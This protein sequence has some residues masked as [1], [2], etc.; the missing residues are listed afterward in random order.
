MSSIVWLN[1]S[2]D[3]AAFAPHLK[4]SRQTHHRF[5]VCCRHAQAGQDLL[6]LIFA[7]ESFANQ[8]V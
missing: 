2:I 6:H 4:D 5:G 1:N 7:G 8:C 3:F